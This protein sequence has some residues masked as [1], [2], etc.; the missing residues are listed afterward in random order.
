MLTFL[1][2]RV[3]QICAGYGILCMDLRDT[4][5]TVEDWRSLE[6]SVFD[7]HPSA[8]NNRLMTVAVFQTFKETWG[9]DAQLLTTD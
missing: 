7:N 5:K 8:L 6:L 3:F 4:F 2:D 9:I 1:H